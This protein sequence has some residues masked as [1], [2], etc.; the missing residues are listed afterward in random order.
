MLR[1]SDYNKLNKVRKATVMNTNSNEQR[2]GIFV[3]CQGSSENTL[4]N[5][6]CNSIKIISVDF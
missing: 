4:S 6:V 3:M 1:D 2:F 5:V